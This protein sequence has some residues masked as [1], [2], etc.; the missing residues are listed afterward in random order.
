[1]NSS[2]YVCLYAK[3]SDN[4]SQNEAVGYS[5][6]RV[7][8]VWRFSY[9]GIPHRLFNRVP[10]AHPVLPSLVS[11][12]CACAS[13]PQ[14]LS[15]LSSTSTKSKVAD[16]ECLVAMVDKATIGEKTNGGF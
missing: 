16:G 9:G 5:T 11:C 4:D 14:V 15:I 7:R 2:F 1:M 8:L 10:V 12:A 13:A 3:C 6:K